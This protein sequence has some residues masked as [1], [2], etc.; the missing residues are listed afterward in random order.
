MPVGSGEVLENL[1]ETLL[2]N[3]LITEME[4][5]AD[6]QRMFTVTQFSDVVLGLFRDVGEEGAKI[7]GEGIGAP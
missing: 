7:T 2:R 4:R 3:G 1:L 5:G 6:N